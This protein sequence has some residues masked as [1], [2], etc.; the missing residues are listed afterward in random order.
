VTKKD[1]G[2]PKNPA[3]TTRKVVNVLGGPGKKNEQKQTLKEKLY[4]LG[5]QGDEKSEK[6]RQNYEV[7]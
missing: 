1:W 7:H 4:A 2:K 6:G 3:S 5:V